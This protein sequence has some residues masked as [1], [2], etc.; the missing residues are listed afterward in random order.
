MK[1]VTLENPRDIGS[2]MAAEAEIASAKARI[3]GA[4]ADLAFTKARIKAVDT[5]I[6]AVDARIDAANARIW[7][8]PIAIAKTERSLTVWAAG[9][10]LAFTVVLASILIPLLLIILDRLPQHCGR[11]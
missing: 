1:M 8:L 3:G 11:G 7:E 4:E 5:R 10:S 2:R 6:D 9:V